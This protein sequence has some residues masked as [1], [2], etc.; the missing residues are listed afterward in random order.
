MENVIIKKSNGIVLKSDRVDMSKPYLNNDDF[1]IKLDFVTKR[2]VE[3]IRRKVDYILNDIYN[4][5]DKNAIKELYNGLKVINSKDNIKRLI[6]L[7]LDYFDRVIETKYDFNIK[8]TGKLDIKLKED[9]KVFLDK[10]EDLVLSIF[11][12]SL[13]SKYFYNC[14]ISFDKALLSKLERLKA[15]K[16]YSDSL[17]DYVGEQYNKDFE[18]NGVENIS[19]KI[20]KYLLDKIFM[21]KQNNLCWNCKNATTGNCQKVRDEVKKGIGDYEFI[22]RGYQLYTNYELESFTVSKCTNFEKEIRKDN[23]AKLNMA[24]DELLE[25]YKNYETIN[26]DKA[27]EEAEDLLSRKRYGH[28]FIKRLIR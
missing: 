27:R 4:Y 11:V 13:I 23:Q 26:D 17:L 8:Y 3:S 9:F 21:D 15:S 19:L 10:K 7:T 16:K 5:Y 28:R 20:F 25:S 18:F 6:F 24:R 12:K 14:L 22:I 1:F 2:D